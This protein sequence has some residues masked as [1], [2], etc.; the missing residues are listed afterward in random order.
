MYIGYPMKTITY[1]NK[2][3]GNK[4]FSLNENPRTGITLQ[5]FKSKAILFGDFRLNYIR[6]MSFVKGK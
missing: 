1:M 3:L 6:L 4:R 5:L 2:N